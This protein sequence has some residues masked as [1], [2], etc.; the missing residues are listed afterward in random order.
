MKNKDSI[1]NSKD[2]EKVNTNSN[3]RT[4]V[5]PDIFIWEI[6]KIKLSNSKGIDAASRSAI[7]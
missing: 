1:E 7:S 2:L 3:K 5:S 4:W 6:N